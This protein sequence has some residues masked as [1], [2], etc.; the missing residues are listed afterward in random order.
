MNCNILKE[1]KQ[2]SDL[3]RSTYFVLFN[4]WLMLNSISAISWHTSCYQ[5]LPSFQHWFPTNYILFA[6][7]L[8][9]HNAQHRSFQY[10][11]IFF[12]YYMLK[13]SYNISSCL[14]TFMIY[15]F[16]R[17]PWVNTTSRISTRV[18]A[19]RNATHVSPNR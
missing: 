4:D 13:T 14:C 18:Y 6:Y 8:M 7:I 11:F 19:T 17:T 16:P 5:L 12:P 1:I 2:Q 9:L 3:K 10:F 15:R